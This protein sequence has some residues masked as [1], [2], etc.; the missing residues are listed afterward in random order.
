MW[1]V[2]IKRSYTRNDEHIL[3]CFPYAAGNAEIFEPFSRYVNSNTSV[4]AMQ[5]PGNGRRFS[6][7]LS[8][9]VCKILHQ[10]EQEAASL[11]SGKT[12]SFLGHSNGGLFAFELASRFIA[13]NKP[14][15]RIFI[16]A[17]APPHIM[18]FK[19]DPIHSDDNEMVKVL[20]RY[21]GT[22]ADILDNVDFRSLFLPII[23]N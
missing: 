10:V 23:R 13:Q 6:E 11:M 9:D 1:F 14:P 16:A 15:V 12:Y 20:R 21:G 4:Y 22:R 17:E 19:D 7:A 18:D 8:N 2:Q 3:F 5:L